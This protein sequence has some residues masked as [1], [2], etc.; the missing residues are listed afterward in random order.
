MPEHGCIHTMCGWPALSSRLTEKEWLYSNSIDLAAAERV[1]T[2]FMEEILEVETSNGSLTF[3][4]TL[5]QDRSEIR[6]NYA[7]FWRRLH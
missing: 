6:G 4:G 2:A 7:V 3:P 1:Q 5:S